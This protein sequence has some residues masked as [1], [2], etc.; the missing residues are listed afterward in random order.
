MWGN[1]IDSQPS[2]VE[3]NIIWNNLVCIQSG[4]N[5]GASGKNVF[6]S[7]TCI[8][9]SKSEAWLEGSSIELRNNIFLHSFSPLTSN[10][11]VYGQSPTIVSNQ[12]SWFVKWNGLPEKW[13]YKWWE[14]NTDRYQTFSAFIVSDFGPFL[15]QMFCFVD[16]SHTRKNLT[17]FFFVGWKRAI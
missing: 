17:Q 12:N 7:N 16:W 1:G 15:R 9:N 11:V 4:T 14:G 13:L 6:H 10:I 5:S 3:N 8:G 2:V